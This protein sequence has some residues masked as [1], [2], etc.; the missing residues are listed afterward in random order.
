MQNPLS[1]LSSEEVKTQEVATWAMNAWFATNRT[2]AVTVQCT[3]KQRDE[4]LQRNAV[5]DQIDV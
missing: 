5:I 1:W 2:T 4:Q 3:H